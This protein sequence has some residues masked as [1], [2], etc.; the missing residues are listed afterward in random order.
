MKWKDRLA[1]N[2]DMSRQVLCHAREIGLDP[3]DNGELLRVI[4][5]RSDDEVCISEIHSVSHAEGWL[6]SESSVKRLI[7]NPGKTWWGQWLRHSEAGQNLILNDSSIVRHTWMMM[8]TM[9]RNPEAWIYAFESPKLWF[10]V[11]TMF[12]MWIRDH[13][14]PI[15]WN[16]L[17]DH[18]WSMENPSF[19]A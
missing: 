6:E 19:L 9:T 5:T 12:P 3:V 14:L 16:S 13:P 10:M 18:R 8:L 4:G 2:E 17:S 7:I 15:L 1:E 11:L